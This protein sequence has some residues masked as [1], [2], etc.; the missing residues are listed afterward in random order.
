VAVTIGEDDGRC[1][2]S[3]YFDAKAKSYQTKRKEMKVYE[4]INGVIC[5]YNISCDFY[6]DWL[7]PITVNTGA[8]WSSW[9]G[10]SAGSNW[11]TWSG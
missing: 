1:H 3:Y 4:E 11:S 9:G 6:I 7:Q 10:W 8:G 5:S 2:F